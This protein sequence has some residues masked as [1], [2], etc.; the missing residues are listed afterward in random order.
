MKQPLSCSATDS[1]EAAIVLKRIMTIEYLDE[2]AV[3]VT[4]NDVRL[5]NLWTKDKV[6]WLELTTSDSQKIT[7]RT[8]VI[9]QFESSEN[10]PPF[11]SFSRKSKAD[12]SE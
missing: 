9:L 4:L 5:T 7:I 3:S 1:L 10:I 12:G 2:N 11:I 8:D 6:E